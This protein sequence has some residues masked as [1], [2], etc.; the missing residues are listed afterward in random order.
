MLSNRVQYRDYTG[1]SCERFYRILYQRMTLNAEY[2][3]FG[4]DW[5][6]LQLTRPQLA[7]MMRD[8][9]ACDPSCTDH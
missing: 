6:T 3:M 4:Y 9:I 8:C 7:S 2:Q 5:T 1:L